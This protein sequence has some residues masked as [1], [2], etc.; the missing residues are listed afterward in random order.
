[1]RDDQHLFLMLLGELPARLSAEQVGWVLNYQAYDVGTLVAARLLNPLGNPVPNSVKYYATVE[2][3]G[4]ARDRTWLAKATNAV[5]Q[6]W[7]DTNMTKKMP[8]RDNLEPESVRA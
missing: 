2:I 8:I 5:S 4:L 6:Y 7:R 1:M 3:L